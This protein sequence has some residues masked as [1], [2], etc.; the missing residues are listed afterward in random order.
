MRPDARIPSFRP[1]SFEASTGRALIL[2]LVLGLVALS[3]R[4]SVHAQETAPDSAMYRV[5]MTEGRVLIGHLVSETEAQVVL[6]TDQLGEVTL[7]RENVASVTRIDPS[8][9]RN[10]EYWF[11]NPQSTRYL[12]APNAL[13]I[14]KGHGYYQNTWVLFNNVNYGISNNFSLGAGTVPIFLFGADAVPIWL[15]PK[16]SISTPQ[17]NLH[18]AGGAVLGAVLGEESE[19]VGLLYGSTTV[20]SRDNNLTLGLGYGYL[21]GDI[22]DSPVINVS[23]MTRLGQKSYLITENYISPGFDASVISLGYRWA[24]RNVAVDFALF[25]PLEDTDGFIAWPWLGVTLPFGR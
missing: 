20:G 6:K 15:L 4:A 5:E 12:F 9:I 1:S 24:S 22:A 19:S 25:R 11:E 17:D 16:V 3:P 14:P 23:G 18:V 10:G 2:A 7:K 13:G 8:R 21:N